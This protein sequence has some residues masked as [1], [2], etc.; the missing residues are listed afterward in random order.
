[1][2]LVREKK[3]N[4]KNGEYL[5]LP[6]DSESGGWFV[7]A[8]KMQYLQIICDGNLRE[9][10]ELMLSER[11]RS[12]GVLPLNRYAGKTITVHLEGGDENLLSG[13][14]ASNG[15][16]SEKL[17]WTGNGVARPVV[18]LTPENGFM[19]DPNG[20]FWY[21]GTWHYFAQLNPYGFG[22]GNTHWMHKTSRDLFHWKTH[23]LAL[24]P[25][26]TGRMY[27]GGG[28]VDIYN[29]SGLKTGDDDPIFLFYT[30]AGCK[31][32]LSQGR[33]FEI[34]CAYSLDGG[35]NYIKYSHN[36]LIPHKEA[37][38]RDPKVLWDPDAHEWI[39]L[40]YLSGNSYETYFSKNLLDWEE[41]ERIEASGCAECPDMFY[42]NLDE[43]SKQRKLILWFCPDSFR[44]GVM[45]NRHFYDETG[46]I[47]GPSAKRCI[48]TAFRSTS[49]GYAAQTFTGTPDGRVVQMSWLMMD[50]QGA[51]FVGCASIPE[52]VK[53]ITGPNGKPALS[54]LPVEEISE[55]YDNEFSFENRGLEEF[56]RIPM[57]AFSKSMDISLLFHPGSGNLIAFTVCGVL[58]VLDI[59][60]GR[61]ILPSG[62]YRVDLTGTEISIRIVTDTCSVEIFMED[63]RFRATEKI[64]VPDMLHNRIV[65]IA[66][67][68]DTGVSVTIHKL[69]KAQVKDRY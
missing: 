66:M 59:C 53:L 55:M 23:P 65:P 27:S 5:I 44:A 56:E 4:V 52:E 39:M 9:E 69:K 10:Y 34:C 26:A 20:L 48:E 60:N 67:E 8:S 11:P 12:Y 57:S 14:I 22:A 68:P 30:A 42:L 40:L 15:V 25:D 7:P 49:A 29:T 50:T 41:G 32:R 64:A 38:N 24:L 31:S 63:G 6:I 61:L 54:I 33:F 16:N 28:V 18:H 46:L 58:I 13:V 45:K 51:P 1:M 3:I 35:E 36:P 21:R 17:N 2:K 43:D 47:A 37:M 62:A 19:N